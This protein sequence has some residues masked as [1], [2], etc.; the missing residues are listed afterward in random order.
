MIHPPKQDES[1]IRLQGNPYDSGFR[2]DALVI[3]ASWLTGCATA[4][5]ET[6]VAV[7]PP[8]VEYSRAE[9]A[10]VAEEVPRLSDGSLVVEM[11]GDYAVIRDQARV[12]G[13]S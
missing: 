11:M 3:G 10:Q 12:C 4:G 8:V 7:C 13:S 5:F 9:Q 2:R 6:G 1:Q